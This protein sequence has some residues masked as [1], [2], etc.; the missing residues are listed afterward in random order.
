MSTSLVPSPASPGIAL[1]S[2]IPHFPVVTP[3]RPSREFG[4]EPR[5]PLSPTDGLQHQS[6]LSGEE[7][8][9]RALSEGSCSPNSGFEGV[10]CAGK[11]R[12]QP[13]TVWLVARI[14]LSQESLNNSRCCSFDVLES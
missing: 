10:A 4:S 14:L 6:V 13:H 12:L 5:H 7:K 2:P 1:S 3:L 8:T 11:R 9:S